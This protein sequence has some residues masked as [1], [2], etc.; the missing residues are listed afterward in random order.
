MQMSPA[1]VGHMGRFQRRAVCWLALNHMMTGMWALMHAFLVLHP[2]Q[3]EKVGPGSS[4][5]SAVAPAHPVENGAGGER[6]RERER[7]RESMTSTAVAAGLPGLGRARRN[8]SNTKTIFDYIGPDCVVKY[9]K[10]LAFY[11]GNR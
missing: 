7:E 6:E 1:N 2:H 4:S 3:L 9:G 10:T 5:G 8:T 11:A